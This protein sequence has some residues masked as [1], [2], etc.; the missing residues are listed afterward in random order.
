METILTFI[1]SIIVFCLFVATYLRL[2]RIEI[3]LRETALHQGQSTETLSGRRGGTKRGE[4]EDEK[5]FIDGDGDRGLNSRM[6]WGAWRPW[7][8]EYREQLV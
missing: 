8:Y 6:C 4:E 1:F 7:L 5:N 2:G 3:I